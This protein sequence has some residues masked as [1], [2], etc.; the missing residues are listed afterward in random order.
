LPFTPSSGGAYTQTIIE[1]S[2]GLL[3]INFK[4]LWKYRELL[5]MLALREVSLRYRQ[6]FLG[7]TWVVLQPLLTTAIFTVIF[8]TLMN[9][10]SE[11][12]PYSVF[13][14][15]GL[16]PWN[17]FAQSLQRAGVSL[18]R[19]IRLITKI[20]FPR[21]IIPIANSISTL[22]DFLVSCV[23]MLVLM[24]IYRIPVTWALLSLPLFLV[25]NL[26]L[27]IGVGLIFAA[28]N[29]YYRDFTY[30][31]PFVI[32]VWM[33]ASPLAYSAKLI[34]ESWSWVYSLNPMVGIIDGFRW[35]IFGTIEFPAN[36]FVFSMVTSLLLF[37][38]GLAV[39]HRL[40]RKF[41]DVI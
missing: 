38:I 37:F 24:M 13:A 40:E 10:P 14:F 33:F 4:E 12:L 15:A 8:G 3:G 18:T 35:A 19:D 5:W 26:L 32:Q 23:L 36:S 39:F 27:A 21:V 16:L 34:P 31:L 20:F 11:G 7:V 2:K 29:V 30:V 17:L 41:A 28:L 1:P 25:F 9:A 6:T 22:V